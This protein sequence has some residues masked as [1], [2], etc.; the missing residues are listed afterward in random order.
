MKGRHFWRADT[1]GGQ[2]LLEGRH[3]WGADTFGG[4]TLLTKVILKKL[5]LLS[6]FPTERIFRNV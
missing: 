3:F 4:Q 1:L 6:H 2:I 5:G